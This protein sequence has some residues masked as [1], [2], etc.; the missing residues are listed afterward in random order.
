MQYSKLA[1]FYDNVEKTSKRLEKTFLVASL[2]K[3]ASAEEL[4]ALV[5]LVQG[6][7]FPNWDQREVGISSRLM[8]KAISIS[9]GNSLQAVEKLWAKVGDLGLVAAELVKNKRQSTLMKK[10]LTVKKVYN[11]IRAI[12]EL[13]GEGTVNRKISLISELYTSATQNDAKFISRTVLGQLRIGVAEGILR[14][15]INWAFFPKVSGIFF[16][17]E[18]CKTLNP[19]SEH[20]LNCNALLDT[21]F[22]HEIKKEYHNLKVLKVDSLLGV[23][24][25]EF[26]KYD[27][28]IA[29]DEKLA[30]E[31]YNYF[32]DLMQHAY[33]MCN[34]FSIVAE[35]AQ[36]GK[37]ALEDI[38]LKVG[39]P[40]NV[41]LAIR[42]D[43]MKEAFEDL[44]SPVLCEF[45]LDGFRVQIHKEGKK[46]WLYTRRLEN[47]TNAFLELIPA[48]EKS[49]KGNSF[50]L[51]SEVVGY[52]PK[53]KKYLAFQ[54]ISQRIR[55]KYEL[56]KT[57]K[58]TP[59][60]INL[61][62]ILYLNG[63]NLIS[64]SQLERREILEKVIEP[65]QGKIVLTK[66]KIAKNIE[67]AND[68]YKEALNAGTEGLVIKSVSKPYT[69]GRKVGGW[70]KIKP[71]LET[72]DLA[73]IGATYGEGKRA[74]MLSSFALA[75]KDE[76][77]G[78]L[79]ECGMMGTGIKEKSEEGTSFY[80]L[81][82]LLTPL[83]IKKEGREVKIK[84][85]IVVEIMYEE[86]QK[87]PNYSSGFALR[88]P[89]LNRLRDDK[90]VDEINTTKDIERI[91]KLQRGRNKH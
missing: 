61:F 85:K 21:K 9:T 2:L 7:V 62:D 49:V 75:A 3:E 24:E 79:V 81:T 5:Y 46:V 18:K 42:I 39:Y 23:K 50:I 45:K 37:K 48:I 44:G 59:V 15:A 58:E 73:I 19:K 51:D 65:I 78:E 63:K 20:C 82:K 64:K 6:N 40:L 32:M 77:T 26:H 8:L 60:E 11:N 30:R 36:K 56:E 67:E 41:M 14:D 68:F 16:E 74:S 91:Y 76:N 84:P 66:K 87:S 29:P 88:F 33:D 38:E 80:D 13:S 31:I 69:P 1:E 17:C 71:N 54:R 22:E 12:A 52:D 25:R 28:I 10:D 27:V 72:L 35:A 57:A 34:D 55:R 83:I 43:D 90:G 4:E 53:T 70:L 47:V 89:R 86:I